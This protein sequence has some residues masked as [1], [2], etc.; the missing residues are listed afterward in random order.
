M[1]SGG[2]AIDSE[3]A[4]GYYDKTQTEP[5]TDLLGFRVILESGVPL[6]ALLQGDARVQVVRLTEVWLIFRLLLFNRNV[7]G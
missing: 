5:D 6:R 4:P 3:S 7:P 2:N 1:N